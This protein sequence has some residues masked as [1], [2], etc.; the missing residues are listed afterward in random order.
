M[1]RRGAQSHSQTCPW[2]SPAPLKD[3]CPG[4]HSSS[5]SHG[6]RLRERKVSELSLPA[7]GSAP[8]PT[9]D[10]G[11]TGLPERPFLSLVLFI[12]PLGF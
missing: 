10:G 9:K 4:E 3:V 1:G 5:Q 12:S 7:P 2:L 11:Q 8:E 6:Q